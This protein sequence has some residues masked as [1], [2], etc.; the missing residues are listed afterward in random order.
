MTQSRQLAAIMFT[1]IVGYTSLMAADEQKAF[2]LLG[3][4]RTFQKPIIEQ[5]GG[6][7]IKE[8]GDGIMA[9]FPTVSDALNAAMRI[10]Q[11]C[12]NLGGFSLRIGI[13]H[14]LFLKRQLLH[15][16]QVFECAKQYSLHHRKYRCSQ[17]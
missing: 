3:R 13:H 2:E 9:S 17:K 8:I 10:Q 7:L 16:H 4:N 5:H 14:L 1:D 6:V 11:E 15:E 12:K